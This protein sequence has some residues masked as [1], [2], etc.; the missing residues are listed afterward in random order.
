MA[1][2][3]FSA[4]SNLFSASVPPPLLPG[5]FSSLSSV[6]FTNERAQ[7]LFPY[8]ALASLM[9]SSLF[10][11]LSFGVTSLFSFPLKCFHAANPPPIIPVANVPP[12]MA[13]RPDDIG[14]SIILPRNPPEFLLDPSIFSTC[15]R[16]CCDLRSLDASSCIE[17]KPRLSVD[18]I[19]R[20]DELILFKIDG[21]ETRISHR[22]HHH[23]RQEDEHHCDDIIPMAQ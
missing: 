16:C 17:R 2:Y 12:T 7:F 5:I 20:F 19:D 15:R 22:A 8:T 3:I 1:R 10:P 14:C 6:S 13:F 23:G 11:I 4:C 21:L 18:A 9:A